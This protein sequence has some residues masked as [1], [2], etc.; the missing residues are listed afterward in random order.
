M[1]GIPRSWQVRK[2]LKSVNK[3][4]FDKQIGSVHLNTDFKQEQ[5]DLGRAFSF[6]Y[7]EKENGAIFSHMA[8]MFS[9]ALYKQGFVQEAWKTLS[10]LYQ[11]TADT[12]RSK[13]YPCLPEYFNLEGRGM[14]PYLTGSASWFMLTMLNQVFGVRGQD[15]DLVIEPKLSAEHFRKSS[16][17]S[18]ERMFAGK[19]IMV[20][21][22]NPGKL[23]YGKYKIIKACLNSESLPID[24]RNYLV[25][26]RETLLALPAYKLN[27]IEIHLA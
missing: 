17:I 18:V 9:F 26:T 12:P 2:I 4:L 11:I 13:V 21:L 1:A 19:R 20:K 15:G 16:S 25:F 6:S 3:Y 27:L 8:V 14:Y 10:S 23:A 5:L 22:L 24:K 7:G